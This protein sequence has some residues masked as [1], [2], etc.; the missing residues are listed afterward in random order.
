M[1]HI[2]P[3]SRSQAYISYLPRRSYFPTSSGIG[4]ATLPA[5]TVDDLEYP[6]SPHSF[7]A[8]SGIDTETR[9]HR[10]LYELEAAEQEYK[11]LVGLENARQAAAIHQRA[12]AEAARHEREIVLYAE[13]ERINRA[14]ALQEQ[15]EER[16]FRCQCALRTHVPVEQAHRRS[17]GPIHAIYCDAE[18][19]SVHQGHVTRPQLDNETLTVDDVLG[20]FSGVYPEGQRASP[21]QRPTLSTSQPHRPSEPQIQ[22]QRPEHENA[23]VNLSDI[24]E[25]FYNIAPQARGAGDREQSSDE[26][27]LFAWRVSICLI[28]DSQQS[29]PSQPEAT[30]VEGKGKGKAKTQPAP[31]RTLFETLFSEIVESA[32]DQELEYAIKLN[33]QDR[34]AADVKKAHASKVSQSSPGASSKVSS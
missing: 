11:A 6:C 8:P 26:V 12:A 27:R 29:L 20:P 3:S 5:Y 1:F 31:E 34:D 18:E 7:L 17:H 30:V 15:V 4:D 2:S 24:L 10:A 25:F 14:R 23:E 9:Y 33:L 22:T 16:L 32:R 13:I 19:D 21:R 28:W